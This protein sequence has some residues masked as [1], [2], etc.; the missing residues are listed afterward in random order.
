MKSSIVPLSQV[1]SDN[2]DTQ[3]QV[4]PLDSLLLPPNMAKTIWS[5][6]NT[7]LEDE[8]A[9]VQAPGDEAAYMVKSVSGQKPHY[10]RPAKNGGYL[11]DD[12]LGYKSAKICAHTVAASLKAGN[13]ETFIKWY[14]KL[15]CKLNLLC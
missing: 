3:Q 12:C 13:I 5:R 6:A 10:V 11:C 8:S 1:D 9:I 2:E 14:K 4:T 15:K 7:L